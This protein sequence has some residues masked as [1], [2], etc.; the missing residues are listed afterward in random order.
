MKSFDDEQLPSRRSRPST[1]SRA[2]RESDSGTRFSP[3]APLQPHQVLHLQRTAG[4]SAVA[5]LLAGDDQ[6]SPVRDI[7]GKGGGQALA[8]PVRTT[9][10]SAFGH[11]F[12]DVRVHTDAAAAQSASS[13]NAKAYTSG[14]DVVFGSNSPSIDSDAGQRTLAH[15]LTHVVQQ[16]SGPVEGTETAGGVSVSDP[17]DRF[18]TQAERVADQ[19]ASGGAQA[20]QV[21]SAGGGSG[22]FAVQREEEEL[23]SAPGAFAVQREEEDEQSEEETE[24]G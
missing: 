3:N 1:E 24:E 2:A 10:E 11:D 19:F 18:E 23:A 7:V 16:R 22:G 9:M 8:D 5:Q 4:N 21:A 14:N 6:E 15:E 13:V 20:S 12:S 17:G